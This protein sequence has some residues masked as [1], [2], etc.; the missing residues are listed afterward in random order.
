MARTQAVSEQSVLLQPLDV[1]PPCKHPPSH[2]VAS[3]GGR[4]GGAAGAPARGGP[5]HR[6]RALPRAALAPTP[7]AGLHRLARVAGAGRQVRGERGGWGVHLVGMGGAQPT[8]LLCPPPAHYT[9][10]APHPGRPGGRSAPLHG[11]APAGRRLPRLA[12]RG[13]GPAAPA[14]GWAPGHARTGEQGSSSGSHPPCPDQL[15]ACAHLASLP[16]IPPQAQVKAQAA[17]TLDAERQRVLAEA[18]ATIAQQAQVRGWWGACG[19]ACRTSCQPASL[20]ADTCKR[21]PAHPSFTCAAAGGDRGGAGGR[22]GGA[23]SSGGRRQARLHARCVR[24]QL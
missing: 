18:G 9:Q 8:A 2:T 24:S 22:A 20:P 16:C 13:G 17:A 21:S 5:P 11:R 15:S 7:H 1:L 19:R 3:G 4:H 10:A 12:R 6:R 23:G 14:G